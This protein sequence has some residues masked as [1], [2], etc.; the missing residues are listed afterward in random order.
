[1]QGADESG[2][3][4]DESAADSHYLHS[5]RHCLSRTRK[6]TDIESASNLP[7]VERCFTAGFK[8]E[9]FYTFAVSTDIDLIHILYHVIVQISLF[10][11]TTAQHHR[12]SGAT[13]LA[14]T[15]ARHSQ[16]FHAPAY[17]PVQ[18]SG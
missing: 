14:R 17:T 7:H 8:K 12:A 4:G 9:P 13:P 6:A 10:Q 1:M 15:P 2:A 3:G 18:W 5:H 16:G 11:L